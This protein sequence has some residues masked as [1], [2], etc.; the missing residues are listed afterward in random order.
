V[1]VTVPIS[2]AA[3]GTVSITVTRDAGVNAVLSG[4]MLGDSGPT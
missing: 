2:P 3:G 4:I 1:W